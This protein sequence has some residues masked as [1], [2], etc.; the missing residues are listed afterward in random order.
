MEQIVKPGE[1]FTQQKKENLVTTLRNYQKENPNVIGSVRL[2]E[3][4][5]EKNN[6]LVWQE[7]DSTTA[8]KWVKQKFASDRLKLSR[9]NDNFCAML[10]DSNNQF[11][12][13]QQMQCIPGGSFIFLT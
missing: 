7:A 4:L 10:N 3:A 8:E 2:Y 9:K 12:S 5:V 1:P 6:W 11:V 13:R